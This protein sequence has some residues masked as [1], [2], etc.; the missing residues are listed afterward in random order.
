MI[1]VRQHSPGN[2]FMLGQRWANVVSNVGPTLA[3]YV[4]PTWICHLG[5]RWAN[6]GEC[7]H[8]TNVG[9]TLA[10]AIIVPTMYILCRP[11]FK[12]VNKIVTK[13][14]C[15]WTFPSQHCYVGP[16]SAVPWGPR[17]IA[18]VVS[19]WICPWTQRGN[20]VGMSTLAQCILI[21][22]YSY[23]FFFRFL[24]PS[25]PLTLCILFHSFH[26]LPCFLCNSLV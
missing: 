2:N 16:T 11:L 25:F 4:G 1:R 14:S 19:A 21:C 22:I 8:W 20:N 7:Q 12:Y 26:C 15:L 10:D 3:N 5:Q 24:S 18:N 23:F 6:V 9:P 13:I 17:W